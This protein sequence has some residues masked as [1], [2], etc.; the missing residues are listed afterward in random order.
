MPLVVALGSILS[1]ICFEI[2]RM[3]AL[4]DKRISILLFTFCWVFCVCTNT[5]AQS[6]GLQ[7][8]SHETLA[9]NRT[10]L[11]LTSEGTICYKQNLEFSFDFS[12]LPNYSIY[13]GY[14]FRLINDQNQNIDLI[15]NQKERTFQVIFGESFTNLNFTIDDSLLMSDWIKM[16]FVIDANKGLTLSY[17]NKQL[18]SKPL[19]LKSTCF[20]LIFGVINEHDFVS[21]DTPPMKVRN[22]SIKPDGK[23]QYFWALNETSGNEAM[24]RLQQKKGKVINANWLQPKHYQWELVESLKIKGSPSIAFNET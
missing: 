16:K 14:V 23:E 1:P 11:N 21:R 6:Y 8:S 20:K 18:H 7:F 24:D 3:T 9:E 12:L 22:I 17:L 10:S 13:F 2:Q 4:F 19:G 15:Y 5:Q